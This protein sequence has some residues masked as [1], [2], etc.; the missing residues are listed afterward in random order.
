MILIQ[1]LLSRASGSSVLTKMGFYPYIFQF[2]ICGQLSIIRCDAFNELLLFYF[3]VSG[4]SH[5]EIEAL[6]LQGRQS[7]TLYQ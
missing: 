5:M 6:P 3:I 7:F 1:V 4:Y 2:N